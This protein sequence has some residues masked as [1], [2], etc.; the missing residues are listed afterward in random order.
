MGHATNG[1]LTARTSGTAFEKAHSRA[2]RACHLMD[3][4]LMLLLEVQDQW[5]VL[6]G[7]LQRR[8]AHLSPG[9]QWQHVGTSEELGP[10]ALAI[11]GTRGESSRLSMVVGGVQSTCGRHECQRQD[12]TEQEAP[13]NVGILYMGV[14]TPSFPPAPA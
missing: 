7:S 5:L 10:G 1:I 2:T 4:L 13:G 12:Y 3:E 14:T 8:V 9:N 11:L 6:H